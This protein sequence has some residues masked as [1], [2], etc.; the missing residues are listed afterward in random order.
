MARITV[1]ASPVSQA[2]PA[3]NTF[4]TNMGATL[5]RIG[6]YQ[7]QRLGQQIDITPIVAQVPFISVSPTATH[8]P[9]TH[10][11][12]FQ[13]LQAHPSKNLIDP[14]ARHN[15]A[16]GNPTA[17]CINNLTHDLSDQQKTL[18][19]NLNR[20]SEDAFLGAL[21]RA[22]RNTHHGFA[23]LNNTQVQ[24]LMS[25]S[26]VVSE[27]LGAL[28]PLFAFAVLDDPDAAINRRW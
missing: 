26:G 7:A 27:Q 2:D 28:L 6:K 21:I 4:L 16:N 25:H 9:N 13:H 18:P 11:P 14:A 12:F 8:D 3:L 22:I 10:A 1:N 15:L 20:I 17:A 24:V 5:N 19:Q 23:S